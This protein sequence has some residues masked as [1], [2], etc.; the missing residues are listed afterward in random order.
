MKRELT[1]KSSS[2]R[3]PLGG[4]SSGGEDED[5]DGIQPC[6]LLGEG[7]FGKVFKGASSVR[8]GL[9]IDMDTTGTLE[10]TRYEICICM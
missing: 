6:E 7:S 8:G 3:R 4:D 9:C 2:S 5:E 1:A 10:C